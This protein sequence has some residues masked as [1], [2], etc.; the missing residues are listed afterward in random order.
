MTL[1]VYKILLE[2]FFKVASVNVELG[3]LIRLIAPKRF[4]LSFINFFMIFT[5]KGL[6]TISWRKVIHTETASEDQ[7]DRLGSF[8]QLLLIGCFL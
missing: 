2:E 7:S 5:I 4:I 3:F 6:E 1:F 8:C